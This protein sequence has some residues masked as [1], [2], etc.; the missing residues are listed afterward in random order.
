MIEPMINQVPAEDLIEEL[1]DDALDRE[2]GDDR[3][4]VTESRCWAPERV[5]L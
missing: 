5:E 2:Y 3:A 4:C 1:K